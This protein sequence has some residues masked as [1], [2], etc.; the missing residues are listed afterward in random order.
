[1]HFTQSVLAFEANPFVRAAAG[2]IYT[3]FAVVII[4]LICAAWNS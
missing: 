4:S 2:F 3:T 1:M